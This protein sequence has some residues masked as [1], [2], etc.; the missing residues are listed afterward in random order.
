MVYAKG[1]WER[2]LTHPLSDVYKLAGPASGGLGALITQRRSC[3]QGFIR[4]YLCLY[5]HVYM[6]VI[7]IRYAAK[8]GTR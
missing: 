3:P 7:L 2:A 5:L 4:D 1:P 6:P 8:N